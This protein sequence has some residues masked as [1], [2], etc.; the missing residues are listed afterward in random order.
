MNTISKKLCG[1][2]LALALLCAAGIPVASAQSF[3]YGVSGREKAAAIGGGATAGA[4]IGGL[5][6][7]RRGAVI[8]GLLGAGGGS[9]YVY[10]KGRENEDRYGYYRDGRY[11]RYNSG[12]GYYADRDYRSRDRDRYDNRRYDR[13]DYR[14]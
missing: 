8:G 13:D 6:G 14:R 3:G 12:Y 10:A 2:V 1:A 4:I 9:A 7:G 11:Y 5:L